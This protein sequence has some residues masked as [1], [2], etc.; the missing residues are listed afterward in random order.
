MKQ[1]SDILIHIKTNIDLTTANRIEVT[2]RQRGKLVLVKS[3]DCIAVTE[4]GLVVGITGYESALFEPGRFFACDVTGYYDDGTRVTSDVMYRPF[5]GTVQG[6]TREIYMSAIF[7]N[8]SVILSEKE[9]DKI[10]DKIED[11]DEVDAAQQAKL[12]TIEEGAEVNVQS[13]WDETDTAEDEY[14]QN[15]PDELTSNEIQ[16]IVDGLE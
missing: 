2:L 9:A 6:T 12:D 8:V 10:W 13:D 7:K 5:E 1:F 14:V 11:I 15:K 3:G 4:E 16:S